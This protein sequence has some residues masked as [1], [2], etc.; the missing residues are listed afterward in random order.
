MLAEMEIRRAC[1]RIVETIAA[2]S[3]LGGDE[4]RAVDH[5]ARRA[6]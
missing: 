1:M 6:A 2:P 5:P 3:K 4:P